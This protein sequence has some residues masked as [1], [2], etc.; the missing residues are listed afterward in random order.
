MPREFSRNERLSSQM[1]RTLNELVRFD[2]KDPRLSGVSL[3][4]IDLSRDLSVAR[5]YFSQMNPE[6]DPADAA[7][8]LARAAG[9]L[10]SRLGSALKVRKVP[11][12]RF[13]H[14]DSIAH[15]AEISRLIDIANSP[16]GS[17]NQ[18]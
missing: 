13:T 1:L 2:S 10:R 11:E 15:G 3:T 7:A 16:G 4:S 12:L 14:D 18:G 6:A 17:D 5:V 9:F 8:G